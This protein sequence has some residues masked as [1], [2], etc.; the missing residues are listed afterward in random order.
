MGVMPGLVVLDQQRQHIEL[1][2][3]GAAVRDSRPHAKSVH[4]VL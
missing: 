4:E 2:R 3:L 1:V